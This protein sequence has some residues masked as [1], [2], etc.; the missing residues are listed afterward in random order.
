MV[1]VVTEVEVVSMM[2]CRF[3]VFVNGEAMGDGRL[4]APLE[5]RGL[6]IRNGERGP[7]PPGA[8]AGDDWRLGELARPGN[9]KLL[10]FRS[11]LR[12]EHGESVRVGP[13]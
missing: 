12:S 10:R 6:G 3:A 4:S 9:T 1:I 8:L 5:S 11:T 2:E 13:G 7:L